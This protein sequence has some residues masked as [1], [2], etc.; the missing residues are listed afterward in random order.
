MLAHIV[1]RLSGILV[2]L[3][4]FGTLGVSLAAASL[5]R[6]ATAVQAAIVVDR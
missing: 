2:P 5:E 4:L 1:S 3:A 6:A